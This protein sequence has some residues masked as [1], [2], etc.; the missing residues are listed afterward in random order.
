M[1]SFLKDPYRL[2]GIAMILFI[3]LCYNVLIVHNG[4]RFMNSDDSSELVLARILASEHGILT[5]NWYYS[6]ELRVFNTNLVFAPMFYLFSSWAMVRAV[7]GSIM[8]LLYVLS[9]LSIPYA[10]KYDPKWFYLTA[11]ILIM[12]FSNPWQ[13]FGLKMYYLPHVF[14]SFTAFSLT[15]AVFNGRFRRTA[16]AVL[17]VFAFIAGLGGAR[18]VEYTFVPLFLAAF[19]SLVFD[20]GSSVPAIVS[21]A[22]VISS[23]AGYA[24]NDKLLSGIYTFHSYDNVS[25][26]RFMLE[27]VEWALD[28]ILTAFGYTIGEYF[29]SFGGVCNA[30]AFAMMIMFLLSFVLLFRKRAVM[31]ETQR[32]MYYFASV[33]FLLNTFLMILGQNDEYADRYIAIGM[34]PCIMFIDLVYKTCLK[35]MPWQKAAGVAVTVFFL[36][37]GANGYLHLLGTSANGERMGYIDFVKARGYDYG[38]ATFWNAN[39]TTEMSDGAINMTS[40]DPNADSLVVFRW[41]TDKRLIEQ[42]HDKAFLVLTAQELDMYKDKQPIYE[43]EYFSVFDIDRDEI[44]FKE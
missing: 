28:S 2:F 38:Y 33:T 36:L 19:I 3:I 20:R 42:P 8:M 29:I 1:K 32:Y 6:S 14:I 16:A 11:F 12:P 13:F 15:G 37:V 7:G 34:V 24:V 21:G 10:W 31:D 30:L 26:I 25:F 23:A 17:V 39:I 9:Y 35:D 22:S 18:S 41:L 5:K 4:W 44:S 40:L 43:D 27:K